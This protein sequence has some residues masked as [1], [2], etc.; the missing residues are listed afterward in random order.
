MWSDEAPFTLSG[1]IN[2]HNC[3]YWYGESMHLTLEQ[4]LSQPGVNVWGDISSSGVLGPFFFSDGTVTIDKHFETLMN[5]VVPQLQ[6]QPNS[7]YFYFQQDGGS[8]HY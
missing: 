5:Q 1:H 2:R 8:P 4:Q 3:I 7:H 6:Q